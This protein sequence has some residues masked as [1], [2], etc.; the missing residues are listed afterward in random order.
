MSSLILSSPVAPVPLE[1]GADVSWLHRARPGEDQGLHSACSLF[2]MANW[3]QIKAGTR[4]TSSDCIALWLE[5]KR[6]FRRLDGLTIP[7][8]F[9]LAREAGWLGAVNRILPTT[10]TVLLHDQPLIAGYAVTP[11]WDTVSSAGCLDHAAPDRPVRDYHAVL[12]VAQ[13][14]LALA[15]NGP[16]VYIENSWGE[17]WGHKGFGVLSYALH[18]KLCKEL[19]LII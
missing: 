6:R 13:G 10:D 9:E 12:I 16:W 7:E 11:A 3:G 2:A 1:D 17:R 14:E 5:G 15:P 18:L 8:A 19:W 4:A